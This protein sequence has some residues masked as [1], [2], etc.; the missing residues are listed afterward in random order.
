[1]DEEFKL[2]ENQLI[3]LGEPSISGMIGVTPPAVYMLVAPIFAL[4]L[5]LSTAFMVEAASQVFQKPEDLERYTRLPVF[6]SFRKI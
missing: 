6:T 1:M 4:I 5:A 3:K 2:Q